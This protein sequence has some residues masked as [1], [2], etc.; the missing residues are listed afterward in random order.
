MAV[1]LPYLPSYKNVAALFKKIRTASVPDAFTYRFLADTIGIKGSGDRALV[2]F[3]KTLGFLDPSGK[4][5]P[6]YN[7]L[8]NERTAGTAI[9]DAIKEAYKPLFSANELVAQSER[10]ELK[11]LVSQVA[12]TD[13]GTTSKIVG[14]FLAIKAIADFTTAPEKVAES[15]DELK[16]P[17]RQESPK[18]ERVDSSDGSPRKMRPEFHYNLQIQLPANGSEETY[19]RIFNA[20]RKVFE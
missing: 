9:A 1:D 3:L 16:D 10:E 15:Q 19:I 17:K 5:T 11:G 12:G 7:L 13:S 18:D 8:K 6:S 4:P 20:I 2:A 14:T